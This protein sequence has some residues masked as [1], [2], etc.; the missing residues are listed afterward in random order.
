MADAYY[1]ED[2]TALS[3]RAI[4]LSFWRNNMLLAPIL[5]LVLGTMKLLGKKMTSQHALAY[6][7][8]LL[9]VAFEQIP[10]RAVE[11]LVPFV[12]EC[13]ALGLVHVGNRNWKAIGPRKEYEVVYLDHSNRIF[14]QVKWAWNLQN[15]HETDV[16]EAWCTSKRTDGSLIRTGHIPFMVWH[17]ELFPSTWDM[18]RSRTLSVGE[19]LQKHQSRIEFEAYL[20]SFRA[21][22]VPEAELEAAQQL[23]DHWIQRGIFCPLSPAEA[24]HL[25]LRSALIAA[26]TGEEGRIL[27]T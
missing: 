24:N 8:Q 14:V 23:F 11:K 3:Y 27:R 7:N 25:K 12:R 21:D 16:V 13:E 2:L 26:Q 5:F 4:W 19:I 20:V 1:W 10:Q 18:A 6:P 15:E 9:S 17:A 22:T